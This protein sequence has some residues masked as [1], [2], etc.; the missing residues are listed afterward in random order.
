MKILANAQVRHFAVLPRP[1]LNCRAGR[2]DAQPAAH[3]RRPERDACQRPWPG[4][5]VHWVVEATIIETYADQIV[6]EFQAAVSDSAPYSPDEF[7]A[8]GKANARL[9]SRLTSSS[10]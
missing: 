5:H 2:P 10:S 4:P 9:M 1:V 7:A 8:I 3:A 6:E